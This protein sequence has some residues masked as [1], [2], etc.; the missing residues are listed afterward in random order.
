[1]TKR[2]NHEG[3]IFKRKDGRWVSAVTLRSGKRWL[4]YSQ[5]QSEARAKLKAMLKQID[6][7]FSLSGSR[8]TLESF[9]RHWLSIARSGLRPRSVVQYQHVI[10]HHVVPAIG[11]I[12]LADLRPDH[13]QQLYSRKLEAGISPGT[14]RLIHAVLHRAF[15]QAVKWGLVAR[16]PLASVEKPR[17]PREEMKVWTIQE[18]QAFLSAMREHRLYALF[19]LAIT[20]GLRRGELLGLKWTDL[21][22]DHLQVQRQLQ[23]VPGQ[24]LVLSEP[25]S[26]AGRRSIALAR[27][28]L[29][30]LQ[31][32]AERQQL[33]RLFVGDD[34]RETG[35]VFTT[36]HGDPLDPDDLSR[37]FKKIIQEVGLPVIRF[38]DMRHTAA[39]I[40]LAQGIHPKVVQERLGHSS[41][42]MTMDTYSHV[43]QNMQRAAADRIDELFSS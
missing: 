39:T 5:T 29:V 1:M 25:K 35:L 15:V 32:R 19:H 13:I 14:I 42:D 11:A 37:D 4:K 27:V 17:Q 31:Q 16:N 9:L 41:I 6:D 3:S 23:R 30:A 22:G 36:L 40:M 33:E 26:G 20:T 21:D 43:L 8:A 28:N 7:G 18:A 2:A 34:W 12:R 24:G 10:D 38:H